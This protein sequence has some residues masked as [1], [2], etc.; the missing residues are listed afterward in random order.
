MRY[1]RPSRVVHALLSSFDADEVWLPLGVGSHTDHEL[2]RNA[3]LRALHLENKARLYF[4]EDVPYA[5]QFPA[6]ADQIVRALTAAGA[7]IDLETHDITTSMRDKLRLVSIYGSQ[8]KPSYMT[9]RV[10]DAARRASGSDGFAERR[11]H[12]RQ[13]P[14]DV[15]ALALSAHR[16]A[17]ERLIPVLRSWYARHESADRIR[18]LTPVPVARW[19]EDLSFLLEAF[20]RATLEMHVSQE[21]ADETTRLS[22]SRIEVNVVPGRELAW[23]AHLTRAAFALHPTILLT[24]EGLAPFSGVAKLLLPLADVITATRMNDF[25][26]ALR[27]V[28]AMS[29]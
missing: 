29:H 12:V 3:C 7:M 18:V 2:A 9:P 26:L 14:K 17:V 11:F 4:Y 8:F 6:H 22:S 20:P 25:V 15:D 27:V 28:R 23:L 10:A 1:S 24:G 13:L 5:T 16:P 19:A 21:Y